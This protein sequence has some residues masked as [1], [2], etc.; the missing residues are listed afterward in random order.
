MVCA[1]SGHR[2]EHL[3]WGSDES[4][5]R[6]RALQLKMRQTVAALAAQGFDTFLC[7]MARGCDI[8]F[9][10]AV[11]AL[12]EQQSELKL[13]AV[14]PCRSQPD[15]WPQQDRLRYAAAL[16][17]CSAVQIVSDRYYP[18]CMLE[19]NRRM[20][21]QADLLLTV[22]DGTHSGTASTVRYARQRSVPIHALWL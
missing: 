3:P 9:F 7:G 19:R 21:D 4:D 12:R 13:I 17:E 22:W 15:A 10:D 2:P 1:F 16:R 8:Y 14:I 6:C 20:V 18:G 11:Q 5:P